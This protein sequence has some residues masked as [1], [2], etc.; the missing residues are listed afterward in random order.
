MRDDQLAAKPF[1]LD[2]TAI[3]WVRAT[4]AKLTRNTR[5]VTDLGQSGGVPLRSRM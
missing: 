3:A 1:H 2:S 5:H 4:F